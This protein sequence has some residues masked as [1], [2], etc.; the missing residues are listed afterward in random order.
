M[1][2]SQDFRTCAIISPSMRQIMNVE[3]MNWGHQDQGRKSDF[4]RVGALRRPDTAARRHCHRPVQEQTCAPS[5]NDAVQFGERGRLARRFRPLAENILR[6]PKGNPMVTRMR[7]AGETPARATEK[8]EQHKSGPLCGLVALPIPTASL[9]PRP[10]RP[11]ACHRLARSKQAT[12]WT[13]FEW[14]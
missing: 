9:R 1:V 4:G 10:A 14:I 5:R 6:L 12:S 11:P 13:E 3:T 2:G 7:L 8:S